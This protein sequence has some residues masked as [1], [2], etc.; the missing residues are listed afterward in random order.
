[1]KK[2]ILFII[3][4]FFITA[5]SQKKNAVIENKS[6]KKVLFGDPFILLH[7]NTYYAYGTNSPNGIE[8]Y[9]SDDLKY[10]KKHT[11]LAL[12]KD[13]SYGEKW[14]WAPEIFFVNG[15]FYMYY[16]AD[17]HICVATSD[18]PLGPFKQ[19]KQ[20][21]MLSAKAIDNSL[22]IDED[23]KA[24]LFFVVFGDG[25]STW[26]AELE[27]DFV[28]LKKETM[29]QCIETSQDWEK[30]HPKV[31]EG[32]YVLKH[33]GIYYMTYSANSYESQFYGI[34]FATADNIFGKW[35]KYDKNPI[36]Q[37]PGNLVGVG[38]SAMFKDKKGK[39]RIAFHAHNSNMSIHPE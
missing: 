25:L 4:A 5:C 23:G 3:L 39:L 33:K 27:N 35:T 2:T 17:E 32:P 10:W 21:P 6:E 8:V 31:N 19:V 24:Y 12:H 20:E 26:V 28:T 7:N 14:F 1:M 38:H 18:S 16:S 34:G 9:T 22:F 36:Y 37:K 13:N 29:H 15:K 30:V 11:Q